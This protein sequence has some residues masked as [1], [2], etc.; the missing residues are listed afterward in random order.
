MLP[1]WAAVLPYWAAV[2]PGWA[3]VLLGWAVALQFGPLLL[4]G[5][6]DLC[7]LGS[8]VAV[9]WYLVSAFQSFLASCHWI[10]GYSVTWTPLQ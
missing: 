7:C 9:C 4:S 2:L 10:A 6:L 1:Y 3:A 5:S 8:F